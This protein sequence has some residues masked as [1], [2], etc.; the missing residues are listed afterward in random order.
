MDEQRWYCRVH[1]VRSQDGIDLKVAV[2]TMKASDRMGNRATKS[3][4]EK[5]ATL[6]LLFNESYTG[7]LFGDSYVFEGVPISSL[8]DLQDAL[9]EFFARP[10]VKDE[11]DR[12]LLLRRIATADEGRN[13]VAEQDQ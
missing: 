6:T 12:I 3:G 5:T 4:N 13:A 9:A 10:A 7:D 1:R 11:V 8:M 2:E